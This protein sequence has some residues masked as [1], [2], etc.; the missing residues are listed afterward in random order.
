MFFPAI[1]QPRAPRPAPATEPMIA[2]PQTVLLNVALSW[3]SWRSGPVIP[4]SE[5]LSPTSPLIGLPEPPGL[6]LLPAQPE[7]ATAIAETAATTRAL[8]VMA[9]SPVVASYQGI[10]LCIGLARFRKDAAR[11]AVAKLAAQLELDLV[12]RQIAAGL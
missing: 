4:G 9:R 7:T 10:S 2:P 5:Q 6:P 8:I 12:G 1:A 3:H 11:L